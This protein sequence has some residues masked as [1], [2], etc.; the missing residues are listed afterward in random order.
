MFKGTINSETFLTWIM[1]PQFCHYH[2]HHRIFPHMV[3][4]L[5]RKCRT[6]FLSVF[7]MLWNPPLFH[8]LQRNSHDL[9][10]ST[11]H[12]VLTDLAI[13][14]GLM[15]CSLQFICSF[16]T[17][18]LII[19]TNLAVSGN[20]TLSFLYHVLN[21]VENPTHWRELCKRFRTVASESMHSIVWI[22]P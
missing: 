8:R 2:L 13:Y 5:K 18:K 21:R 9:S 17:V 15:G 11:K 3:F 12:H 22:M 19:T 14:P 6:H 4:L 16:S 7:Y 1:P 20:G 10:Q